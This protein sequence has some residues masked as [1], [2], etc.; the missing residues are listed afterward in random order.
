[1]AFSFVYDVF[2]IFVEAKDIFKRA[3]VFIG[4]CLCGA[5]LL[6]TFLFITDAVNL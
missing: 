2:R 6:Y 3:F 4:C 1:M 5:Y